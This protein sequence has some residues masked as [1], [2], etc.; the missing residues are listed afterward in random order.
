MTIARPQY[1]KPRKEIWSGDIVVVKGD[2][3]RGFY[4]VNH[5]DH[6]TMVA[7]CSSV[8]EHGNQRFTTINGKEWPVDGLHYHTRNLARWTG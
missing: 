4:K 2:F 6:S 8:D 7:T 1:T 5:V 3:I